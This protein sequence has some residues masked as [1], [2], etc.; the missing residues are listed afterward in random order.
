[1]QVVFPGVRDL[2]MDS[3]NAL[4]VTGALGTT[5]R[6]LVLAI[7]L[8]GG[9]SVAVAA[10]RQRLEAEINADLTIAGRQIVGNF[11]LET[12]IPAAARVLGEA[13]GLDVVGDI[14]QPPEMEFPLEIDNMRPVKFHGA[15]DKWH[16]TRA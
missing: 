11:T 10:C 9:N 6:S 12:D 16:P 7:V 8:Q 5:K 13:A 2:G 1:M 15:L 14:S 3:L 4:F